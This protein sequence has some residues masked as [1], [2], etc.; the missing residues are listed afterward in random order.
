[1]MNT[2]PAAQERERAER[3]RVIRQV[4]QFLGS[5][6]PT[7]RELALRVRC[8]VAADGAGVPQKQIAQ[9]AGISEPAVCRRVKFSRKKL[10]EMAQSDRFAQLMVKSRSL[11]MD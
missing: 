11:F 10:A 1:M 5:G 9:N 8:L 2:E 4:L 3:R 7:D 6:N